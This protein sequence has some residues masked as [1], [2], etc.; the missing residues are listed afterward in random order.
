MYTV[1]PSRISGPTRRLTKG[2]WTEHEIVKVTTKLCITA[3][4]VQGR[5]DVQCLH[6]WQK[7]LDPNLIKGHWTKQEDDI[8]KEL[9]MVKGEKKWSEIAKHLPGRIGKQCKERALQTKEEELTL[10]KA[11]QIYGNK[12]AEIAKF[13]HGRSENSIKN[14]WNCSLRKK[15]NLNTFSSSPLDKFNF[16]VEGEMDN[17]RQSSKEK[18]NLD[19]IEFKL[20]LETIYTRENL[21]QPMAF[22]THINEADNH[23]RESIASSVR[24][25]ANVNTR[26]IEAP[27]S[28]DNT[29][30]GSLPYKAL[31]LKDLDT[32]GNQRISKH[33]QLYTKYFNFQ[34]FSR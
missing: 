13:M 11:H 25:E 27:Q 19:E 3:E 7:V 17:T 1:S 32:F 28:I 23:T 14:H 6:R 10:I 16:N 5:T 12:W 31:Q 26:S 18:A 33:G 15:V 21:A 20:D 22:K 8:I 30:F 4:S 2:G 34:L 9:I 29:C 24:F